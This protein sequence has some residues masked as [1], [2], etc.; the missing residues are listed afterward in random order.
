MAG[1][2]TV[3]VAGGVVALVVALGLAGLWYFFLRDDAPVAVSLEAALTAVPGNGS[4]VSPSQLTGTWS[5]QASSFAGYRVN[6]NLA[7]FGSRTAVGR[8]STLQGSLNYDGKTI[9]GVKVTADD[10]HRPGRDAGRRRL[11]FEEG[12]RQPDTARRYQAR[13][14]R[15]QRP[16]AER[17]GRHR[18][19]NRH[20]VRRLQHGAAAFGLRRFAGRP[21][22]HGVSAHLRQGRRRLSNAA[23]QRH[24]F[25]LRRRR[26]PTARGWSAAGRCARWPTTWRRW[27]PADQ[28][29]GARAFAGGLR[30]SPPRAG[31]CRLLPRAGR[32]SG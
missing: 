12:A 22:H 13:D 20:Q 29:T 7:A 26:L 18:R 14:D 19:L 27:L 10:A 17:P 28:Y 11:G 5:V 23:G 31:P 2:K 24:A 25:S 9:S 16:A 30:L 15:R 4:A 32:R 8:T 1:R 6:E 21:R 3:L